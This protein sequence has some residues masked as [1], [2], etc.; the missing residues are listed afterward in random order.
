MDNALSYR[1]MFQN[2]SSR[3]LFEGA[4]NTDIIRVLEQSECEDDWE[5]LWEMLAKQELEAAVKAKENGYSKTAYENYFRAANYFRLAAYHML[6]DTEKKRGLLST[7]YRVYD[8]GIRFSE[9][10]IL[11]VCFPFNGTS[12]SG[13]LHIPKNFSSAHCAIC[14]PGLGHN[15]VS[16]HMWCRHATERGIAVLSADGPGYGGTRALFGIRLEI[17]KFENYVSS[18]IDFLLTQKEFAVNKIGVF[19]DCFGGYLAFRAARADD[20]IRACAI[21]EGILAFGE[22]Q[23]FKKNIPPLVTY[24]LADS[25]HGRM[26]NIEKDYFSPHLIIGCPIR[27]IHAKTDKMIPFI[28]AQRIYDSLPVEKELVCYENDICYNNYLI[29]HYNTVL[30]ELYRCVPDAWDWMIKVLD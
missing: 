26:K 5:R 27:M 3:M 24:H 12:I 21:T 14:I 25:E 13:Y 18:A 9:S 28:I 23:E 29:N 1:A 17:D 6:N 20:R 30:D 16:M 19:G 10:S 15:S 22:E 4:L 8:E 2:E 7:S 11:K